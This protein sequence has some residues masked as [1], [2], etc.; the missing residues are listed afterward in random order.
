MTD[1]GV[2]FKF[3]SKGTVFEDLVENAKRPKAILAEWGKLLKDE[4]KELMT[5]RAPP[6]AP[7]TIKKQ[8]HQ[9]TASITAQGKVRGSYAKGLD[10]LLKRKGINATAELRRLASGDT[11][12]GS[13]GIKVIDRLRRKVERAK[14][15]KAKGGKIDIGKKTIE[16]TGGE[17]GG[18]FRKAWT[19][20]YEGLSVIVVNAWDKSGIHDTGGKVGNGA[21]LPNWNFTEI[22][23]KVRDQ[24]SILAIDWL[25]R[26]GGK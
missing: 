6:L 5:D 17:R 18:K 11:S 7:S 4:A 22:R 14:L 16:R 2:K 9:G 21:T 26:G 3:N 15:V 8:Q 1:I 19:R 10:T 25:L 12:R 13:K 23:Q 24:M 20:V